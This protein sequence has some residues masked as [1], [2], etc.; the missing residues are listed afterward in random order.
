MKME[1][2]NKVRLINLLSTTKLFVIS[3]EMSSMTGVSSLKAMTFRGRII[4]ACHSKAF[5]TCSDI[6]NA[7]LTANNLHQDKK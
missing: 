2:L 1:R 5:G 4:E 3:L 6:I 7:N